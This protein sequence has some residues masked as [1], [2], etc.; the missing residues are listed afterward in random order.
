[1]P[2]QKNRKPWDR[3]FFDGNYLNQLKAADSGVYEDPLEMVRIAPSASNLQPWRVIKE[4]E[5]EVFRFFIKKSKFYQRRSSSFKLT[6][7]Q[8]RRLSLV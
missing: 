5:K 1:M 8:I 4:K 2:V 6:V 3:L 7:Y